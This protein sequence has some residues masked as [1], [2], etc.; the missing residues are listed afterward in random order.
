MRVQGNMNE[1][2]MGCPIK[3]KNTTHIVTTTIHSYLKESSSN[4]KV[5]V[6]KLMIILTANKVTNKCYLQ[7]E[8]SLKYFFK[9]N[10]WLLSISLWYMNCCLNVA[11]VLQPFTTFDI[12]SKTKIQ[13]S[14][15][16]MR[17]V[18]ML[19][20]CFCT[21]ELGEHF[22]TLLMMYFKTFT[23]FDIIFI[24]VFTMYFT[25]LA[26][27]PPLTLLDAALF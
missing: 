11:N 8:S 24:T 25:L 2:W 3:T 26:K 22:L 1:T 16:M 17:T 5:G 4:F 6:G 9:S 13:G 10:S 14:I 21:I 7:R 18:C 19:N 15:Q 20:R 27:C 23:L 12:L